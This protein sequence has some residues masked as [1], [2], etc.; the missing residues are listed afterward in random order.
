MKIFVLVLVFCWV[1]TAQAEP[2]LMLPSKGVSAAQL[3]VVINQN[4]PLSVGVGELYAAEHNIPAS[5][6]VR[7]H[8]SAENTVLSAKDFE[9]LK[10]LLDKKLDASVQGLLLTWLKPYRVEC[11][12]ITSAFSLGWDRKYC[13]AKQCAPTAPSPYFNSPSTQ[14]NTQLG[15]RPSMLLGASSLEEAKMLIERAKSSEQTNPYGTAYLVSTTD[16]DRNVRA[17]Y[18]PEIQRIFTPWIKVET[19]V[20]NALRDKQDVMFYF[21]G[22]PKVEDIGSNTFLAGAV[23]DHLTSTGGQLTDSKQMSALEWLKAGA[24]GSYGTV[25]EPC[26]HLQKFPNP[27]VLMQHYL[28][29]ETLLESYWKSVA[30]PGEG[31]FVGEPLARP[32]RGYMLRKQGSA[33]FFDIPSLAPGKYRL[34]ASAH[35]FGPYQTIRFIKSNGQ[36]L[37]YRVPDSKRSFYRLERL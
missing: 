1:A 15:F 10:V 37:V 14:P 34:S 6:I 33:Y 18:F 12:S 11:M 35:V 32:Y 24:T 25:V 7:L 26:A 5:Q 9:P 22:L 27:G 4:D 21:T 30:W 8:F 20:T 19:P 28:A 29:G 31:V 3:A 23:A 36:Q 13:S 17:R 2:Q 16:R